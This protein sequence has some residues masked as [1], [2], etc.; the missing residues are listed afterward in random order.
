MCYNGA[1][2]F[3]PHLS[4]PHPELGMSYEMSLKGIEGEVKLLGICPEKSNAVEK[5]GV[6]AVLWL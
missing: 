1:I 4:H 5:P 2:P 6:V 3:P